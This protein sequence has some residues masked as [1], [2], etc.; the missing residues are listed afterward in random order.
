MSVNTTTEINE[1]V[2]FSGIFLM[3]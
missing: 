3:R 1:L 2:F